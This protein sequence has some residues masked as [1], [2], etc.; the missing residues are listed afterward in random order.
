VDNKETTTAHFIR[1]NE[2]I[3]CSKEATESTNKSF[4]LKLEVVREDEYLA[5][6]HKPAGILVSGNSFKTID[7]AL[8]QNLK[9][10]AFPDACRPRPVHRLDY[11]TTGLLLV[12]KTKAAITAL[13][14]LFE[15]KQIQKKYLAITI[16]KMEP[17]GSIVEPIDGKI[18]TS[19][20]KCIATVDSKRFDCLN[21]VLLEPKTGRRHQ[22][23]KHLAA[24]G[25]GIL[26]DREYGKPELLLKG[27]GMYLHAY[28][29]A[30][31]HPLSSEK[32]LVQTAIP[33][34]FQK[35]IGLKTDFEPNSFSFSSIEKATIPD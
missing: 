21:F 19:N 29:L 28:S 9:R 14:Q 5:V 27:K 1:G 3:T 33:T 7:N 30:F 22:L 32:L 11:Q 26:G 16:G 23:R 31:I 15:T 13:N 34:R 2:V 35:I 10:S 20:Y 8:V 4:Q 24:I 12:G 25:N 17:Q 6:I 18:A